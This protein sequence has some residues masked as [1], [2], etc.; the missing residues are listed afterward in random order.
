MLCLIIWT[1]LESW[2][3]REEGTNGE[4]VENGLLDSLDDSRLI[5]R[6]SYLLH[7]Q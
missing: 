2:L 6:S 4:E 7:I 3:F 5:V 1:S